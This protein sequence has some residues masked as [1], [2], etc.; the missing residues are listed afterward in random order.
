M[1]ITKYEVRGA[2]RAFVD[3]LSKLPA[4]ER[5]RPPAVG[6]AQ[7]INNLIT[8]AREVAPEIDGRLWPQ[9]IRYEDGLM[10]GYVFGRYADV[11]TAA[12]RILELIPADIQLGAV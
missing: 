9:P 7:E 8:L 5:E 12:R 2:A 11:E 6:Y 1:A 4:K 3:T 10:G